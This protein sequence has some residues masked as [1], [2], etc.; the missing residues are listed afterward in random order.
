MLLANDS[1]SSWKDRARVRVEIRPAL[2]M[3][4]LFETAV[5]LAREGRTLRNGVPKPLDL[6]LFV[7]EFEQETRAA[8]PPHSAVRATLTP[9]AWLAGRR[10][11]GS[12]Y[13][14][15]PAVA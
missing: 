14:P 10:G 5:A 3:E 1:R 12:R 7:R 11:Y 15:Q 13:T 9:L 2:D 4:R 6:A 8:F